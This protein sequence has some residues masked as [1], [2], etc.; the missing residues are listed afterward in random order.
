M[1]NG[2]RV[3]QYGPHIFHTNNKQVFMWLSKFTEWTEYQHQVTAYYNSEFLT[4]PPN[5]HTQEVLGDRLF[6]VLYVPY[7][8]KM[9]GVSADQIDRAVLDRVK[10]RDDLNL[11]YFPNDQFQYLP[12]HGYT[13]LF[14]NMLDHANIKLCLSTQFDK[15]MEANY[16][17]VFNSMAI[18]EYYD[19]CYGEL[20]YRSVRF[21]NRD[22][23]PFDMPT[24][25]VNFTDSEKY[26]RI[27][28]WSG[29]PEHGQGPV[30]TLEEPCDYRD[31]NNQRFYPVR[32]S[33]GANRQIYSQYRAI[34]NT[35]TQFI[36]R[37]GLYVYIDMD[38]AVS[39][40]LATV[41]KFTS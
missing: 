3:H 9:W 40:A 27:T 32:D 35:K 7:T 39:M 23:A 30:Y 2:V 36:G 6:D 25:V 41:E 11:L 17:Y 1:V 22:S 21:H 8:E 38:M 14:E 29:F 28:N 10:V 20:P 5:R 33:L 16:D 18:D 31:N 24:T 26:T 13:K 37:C 12:R 34:T 15:S 19:F 4:L